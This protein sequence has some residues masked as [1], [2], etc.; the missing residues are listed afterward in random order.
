[1][2]RLIL[3]S[4]LVVSMATLASAVPTIQFSQGT[5]NWSY[6]GSGTFTFNQTITVALGLGGSSSDALVGALVYIPSLDV[7]GMPDPPYAVT[8]TVASGGTIMIKSSDNTKTY[9]TGTLGTGDIIPAGTTGVVYTVFSTDISNITVTA[10]GQALGSDALDTIYSI[11][12]PLLDFELSLQGGPS[13]GFEAMLDDGM[14][15]TDGLSGAMTI[16]PAPGAVLLGSIGICLVGWL[17]RR[18]TL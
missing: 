6:D 3:T 4:I 5:G 7:S 9:M 17:R 12:D 16:I 14:T 18:R 8:P 11:T 2:R 13:E 15:G 1:M 10:D